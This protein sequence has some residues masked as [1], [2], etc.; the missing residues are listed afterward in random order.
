MNINVHAQ[1]PALQRAENVFPGAYELIGPWLGSVKHN[2]P[3]ILYDAIFDL[4]E[5]DQWLQDIGQVGGLCQTITDIE[6]C[7]ELCVM[8]IGEIRTDLDVLRKLLQANSHIWSTD[9]SNICVKRIGDS[10]VSLSVSIS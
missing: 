5:D 2:D 3:E 9:L 8:A 7:A 6:T 1:L 4:Y 10:M